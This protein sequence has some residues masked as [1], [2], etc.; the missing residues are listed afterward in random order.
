MSKSADVLKVMKMVK[1]RPQ[2][3]VGKI[4]KSN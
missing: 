1:S 2:D 3:K 4:P